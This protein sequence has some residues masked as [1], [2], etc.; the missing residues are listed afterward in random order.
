MKSG[1]RGAVYFNALFQSC[2]WA[3][4]AYLH[5]VPLGGASPEALTPRPPRPKAES[6]GTWRLDTLPL[7]SMAD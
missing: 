3:T 1:R 6:G 7:A 5:L 2:G 4:S